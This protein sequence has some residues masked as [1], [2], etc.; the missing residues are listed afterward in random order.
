MNQKAESEKTAVVVG[1]STHSGGIGV[2]FFGFLG[3]IVGAKGRSPWFE[4]NRK[5]TSLDQRMVYKME[6]CVFCKIVS[7]DIPSMR[8]YEDE[9]C[10]AIMDINPATPGHVLVVPKIHMTDLTEMEEALAGRLLM[11]AKRIGMRQKERLGADG[12]NVVQN[13]GRAAGQTVLHFH[14]HVIPRYQHGP[15][16]VAWEP[17]QPSREQLSEIC[18]KLS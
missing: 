11:V 4:P 18:E 15:Q 13:N 5:D 10:I 8:V 14:I 2:D 9:D 7:G 16:M 1:K 17:T 3:I 12:F 6:D